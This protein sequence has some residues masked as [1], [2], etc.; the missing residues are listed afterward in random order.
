MSWNIKYEKE[1]AI[2]EKGGGKGIPGRGNVNHKKLRQE[3]KGQGGGW[4]TRSRV[5]CWGWTG[6]LS[7][8][9]LKAKGLNLFTKQ[10]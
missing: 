1:P 5:V 8:F 3:L 9:I 7:N 6:S 2:N 4:E 10:K